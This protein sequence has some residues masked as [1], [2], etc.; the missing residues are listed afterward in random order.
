M[1][2]CFICF[3]NC[4]VQVVGNPPRR[5][6]DTP[7]LSGYPLSGP[8]TMGTCGTPALSGSPQGGTR[9]SHIFYSNDAL[10]YPDALPGSVAVKRKPCW[11]T[12]DSLSQLTS[13]RLQSERTGMMASHLPRFLTAACRMMMILP[14]PQGHHDRPKSLPTIKGWQNF[15]HYKRALTQRER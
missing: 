12:S 14:S 1:T 2:S 4:I 9:H 3:H 11:V 8:P 5:P 15:W 6:R 10:P 13:H 7:P